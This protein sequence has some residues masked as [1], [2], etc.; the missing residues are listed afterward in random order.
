MF[1]SSPSG[2]LRF[3]R[4]L[5]G[6]HLQRISVAAS[7]RPLL[8]LSGR[9][10]KR[11]GRRR[12]LSS[13]VVLDARRALRLQSR[14]PF[15]WRGSAAASYILTAAGWLVLDGY[16]VPTRPRLGTGS[17]FRRIRAALRSPPLDALWLPVPF[18]SPR[19][20]TV[21]AEH[22]GRDAG[23]SR[24][25]GPSASIQHQIICYL[26]CINVAA[27]AGLFAASFVRGWATAS[28]LHSPRCGFLLIGLY[29]YFSAKT[30]S[31]CVP[32]I[33][34]PFLSSAP[35]PIAMSVLKRVQ[36]IAALTLAM[37]L[38]TVGFGQVEGAL[39]L[40]GAGSNR[41]HSTSDFEIPSAW[42]V[43][44]PSFLV[45]FWLRCSSHSFPGFDKVEYTAPSSDFG[46]V[47]VALAFAVL[48]P[49]HSL[50]PGHRVSMLWLL[51]RRHCLWSENS[52]SGRSVCLYCSG[53]HRR[54][55]SV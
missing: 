42:F 8:A 33:S 39:F 34:T 41:P 13:L 3:H 27:S 5:S 36:I 43:G 17:A 14:V 51:S 37:M 26:S 2:I 35:V 9:T 19:T 48:I 15:G 20:C 50:S 52:S 21:Q 32:K 30:D 53:S 54:A 49:P 45:L 18:A 1:A 11:C 7:T 4:W 28:A 47:A 55:S 38:F 31:A 16:W 40:W 6:T 23:V 46:L 44:L 25:Q 29:G 10:P 22:P 12:H 24:A